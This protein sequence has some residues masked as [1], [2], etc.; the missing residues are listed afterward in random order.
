MPFFV[1]NF[2]SKKK[3]SLF[4]FFNLCYKTLASNSVILIDEIINYIYEIKITK[5]IK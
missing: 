4:F 2:L 3:L 5:Q 1:G